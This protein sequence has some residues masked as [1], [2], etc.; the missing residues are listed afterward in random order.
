[1]L[2]IFLKVAAEIFGLLRIGFFGKGIYFAAFP[3]A[4]KRF[5][6]LAIVLTTFKTDFPR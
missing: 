2:N 6:V 1:M 5:S 3:F 4:A